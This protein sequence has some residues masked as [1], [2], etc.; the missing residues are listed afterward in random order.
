MSESFLHVCVSF[1]PRNTGRFCRYNKA[2]SKMTKVVDAKV[3]LR[4]NTDKPICSRPQNSTADHY[5]HVLV[6]KE[7][8]ETVYLIHTR[9]M[10]CPYDLYDARDFF[11]H[12]C[13]ILNIHIHFACVCIKFVSMISIWI[14]NHSWITFKPYAIRQT[15]TKLQTSIDGEPTSTAIHENIVRI[16]N[17]GR[18]QSANHHSLKSKSDFIIE[19]SSRRVY[20]V[21]LCTGCD[22]TSNMYRIAIRL[23]NTIMEW[24]HKENRIIVS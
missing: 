5:I 11:L 14:F 9:C 18:R 12:S 23:A 24:S 20:D 8:T 3:Y 4:R 1:V 19:S 17:V 13:S 21:C 16:S 6:Y 7:H 22:I 10:M 2:S 15:N